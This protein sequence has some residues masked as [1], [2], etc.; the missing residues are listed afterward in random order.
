MECALV[1]LLNLDA[2]IDL[3]TEKDL[4]RHSNTLDMTPEQNFLTRINGC[5]VDGNDDQP[6]RNFMTGAIEDMWNAYQ[7]KHGNAKSLASLCIH[8]VRKSMSS[9]DDNSFHSLPVPSRIRDLL[10]LRNVAD[11]LCEAWRVWPKCLSIQDI[12]DEAL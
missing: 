3:S 12:V 9:L 6:A 4:R 2:T 7:H 5:H 11:I 10:M 1:L 8:T